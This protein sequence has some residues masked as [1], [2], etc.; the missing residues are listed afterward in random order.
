MDILG[1]EVTQK[2]VIVSLDDWKDEG[3]WIET[4]NTKVDL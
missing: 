1:K 2:I 3:T 4:S